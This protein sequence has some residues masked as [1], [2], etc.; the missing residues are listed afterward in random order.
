MEASAG[1]SRGALVCCVHSFEQSDFVG[2]C[3]FDLQSRNW[4][5]ALYDLESR[6]R[7]AE[8]FSMGRLRSRYFQRR[9]MVVVHALVGHRLRLA[10]RSDAL[11]YSVR[12]PPGIHHFVAFLQEEL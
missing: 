8:L 3:T 1:S 10:C 12:C 7:I 11:R 6:F 2:H 9:R 4:I 5:L